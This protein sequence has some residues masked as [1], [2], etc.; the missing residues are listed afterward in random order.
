MTQPP[1]IMVPMEVKRPVPCISGGAG[2][3][4]PPGPALRIDSVI[5]AAFS[6]TGIPMRRAWEVVISRRSSC[7]H[8]TPLGMPVVPPV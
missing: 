3:M 4:R 6:G 2:R 1:A 8:I 5:S 7:A